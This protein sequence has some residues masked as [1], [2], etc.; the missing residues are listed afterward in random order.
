MKKPT[1]TTNGKA[2]GGQP[3]GSN[4]TPTDALDSTGVNPAQ[5]EVTFEFEPEKR[6]IKKSRYILKST[7][8]EAQYERIDQAYDYAGKLI[9]TLDFRKMG[10]LHPAGRIK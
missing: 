6:V 8:N 2:T 7:A 10:V 5:T 9:S 1:N 4:K 3:D